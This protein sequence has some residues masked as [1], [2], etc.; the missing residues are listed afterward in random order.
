LAKWRKCGHKA[1]KLWAAALAPTW[2]SLVAGTAPILDRGHLKQADIAPKS[3][4]MLILVQT[5]S[6]VQTQLALKPLYVACLCI[7]Q[8]HAGYGI[9]LLASI[10]KRGHLKQADVAPKSP[11]MLILGQGWSR[12]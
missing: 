5:C 3:P 4:K 8:C 7:G 9:A 10:R 1:H 6:R 11:K 12:V 2:R